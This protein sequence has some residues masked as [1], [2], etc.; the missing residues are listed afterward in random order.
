[1]EVIRLVAGAYF[2]VGDTVLILKPTFG[3]YELA[4][5]VAGADIIEQWQMKRAALSLIWI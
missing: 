4:V 5:E 2:G 1:M 3:E